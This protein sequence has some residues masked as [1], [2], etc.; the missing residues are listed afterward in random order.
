MSTEQENIKLEQGTYEILRKRL[1]SQTSELSNRLVNLN[2]ARKAVFGS[3]ETKLLNTQRISTEYN[4]V[5][6]DM[7]TLN[8]NMLFGYNVQMGLKS[9]IEI[10]DVL[11]VFKFNGNEF[12]KDNLNLLN[13]PAF[14]DD[15]KNLYRYYKETKF[16]KFFTSLPYLYMVFRIG[17]NDNDIKAF[18]WL[19]EE[20][21]SLTYI[22]AR[23]EHEINYPKQ[24]EFSWKKT[25]R[26][27]HR[28]GTHS[29]ISI[30]EKVFVETIGGDLTVKIEDNTCLLYT[31]PSPRDGA[32]SRMPSSA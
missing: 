6:W 13:H 21:G 29:H 18:K 8:D 25:N 14:H 4:C 17:K 15:F 9:E 12:K 3:I 30:E 26:S 2:E 11:S 5:A 7:F 19:I 1:E 27:Q 24:H 10:S 28:E 16:V 22:D 32:T 23:S 31:S 20:D